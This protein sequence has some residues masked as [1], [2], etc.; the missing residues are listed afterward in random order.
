[1][2][3]PASGNIIGGDFFLALDTRFVLETFMRGV[4]W[5]A[6]NENELIIIMRLSG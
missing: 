6:G 2:G 4:F 3:W 1:M 5:G